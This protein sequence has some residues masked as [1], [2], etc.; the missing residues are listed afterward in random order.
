MQSLTCVNGN[1]KNLVYPPHP[2]SYICPEMT[3]KYCS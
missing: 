3:I 2:V 1:E